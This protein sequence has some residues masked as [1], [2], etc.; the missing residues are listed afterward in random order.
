MQ[1]KLKNVESIR[2]ILSLGIVYYHILH[3]NIFKYTNNPSYESLADSSVDLRYIVEM[4]F[5]IAGFF[6][7]QSFNSKKQSMA[8]FTI[9]KISRL[10]PVLAFS[11][12]IGFVACVFNLTDTSPYSW[13]L[14]LFFL[15]NTGLSLDFKGI[16][17][18]VSPYFWAMIL[19]FY[20]LKNTKHSNLIIALIVYF[21][22]MGIINCF[23]GEFTRETFYL[24]FNSGMLRAFI[25]IGAG[26]FIGQLYEKVKNT[27][28]K[29]KEKIIISTIEILCFFFILYKMLISPL[30]YQ[31][32]LIYVI[33]FSV[34]FFLFVLK[35]GIISNLL[36]NKFLAFFGKYSYSIYIMQQIC[37][38]VFGI[39]I[40][41]NG[42]I[43]NNIPVC[44][45]ISIL[46]SVAAGVI[47]YYLIEVPVGRLIKDKLE[48]LFL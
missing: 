15:Q 45:F 46:L 14:N 20:I 33:I 5:I 23:G 37:F 2:F 31:N 4:F 3:S 30:E 27:N 42:L 17:W 19:Y 16:N 24:F 35:K 43:I 48:K 28:I 8:Q 21:S 29:I 39:T 25:G 44:L 11:I 38:S 7:F 26:Y 10:F 41:K 34:L 22:A 18:F 6:L 12:F 36:D 13:F 9:N 47:V 40:W 32:K 1:N